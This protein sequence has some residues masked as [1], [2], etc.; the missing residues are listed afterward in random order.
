MPYIVRTFTPTMEETRT[1]RLNHRIT[2]TLKN[3]LEKTAAA[4]NRSVG[5]YVECAVIAML[6]KDEFEEWVGEPTAAASPNNAQ[7]QH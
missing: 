2:P 6:E 3:R 1:A 5:N 4:Q 7:D